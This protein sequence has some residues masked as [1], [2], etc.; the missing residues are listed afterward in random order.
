MSIQV[1]MEEIQQEVFD[2]IEIEQSKRYSKRHFRRI[3][4][5]IVP[6]RNTKEERFFSQKIVE[7]T[8][9]ERNKVRRLVKT[10]ARAPES[11]KVKT[12]KN[13]AISSAGN[14]DAL[15]IILELS[16]KLLSFI[17]KKID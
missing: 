1:L 13:L 2:L 9:D 11:I 5:I 14:F 16:D 4:R 3:W 12:K 10:E 7:Q 15:K 8:F 6:F 17:L